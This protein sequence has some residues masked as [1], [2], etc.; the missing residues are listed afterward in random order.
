MV[1]TVRMGFEVHVVVDLK[2][3]PSEALMSELDHRFEVA[4]HQLG[5]KQVEI[6]EHVS[7]NDEAD[8]IA[9]VRSLVDDAIPQGSKIAAITATSD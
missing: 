5:T 9:F 2:K 8:A 3:A 6:T 4:A 1:H 7:V